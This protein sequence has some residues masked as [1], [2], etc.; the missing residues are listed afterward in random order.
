MSRW[1]NLN[2]LSLNVKKTKSMAFHMPRK[3]IIQPDIG[4]QINGSNIEFADN[5]VFLGITINNEL[6]WNSH[7][8]K[9]QTRYPRQ[10]VY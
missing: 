6:N 2:K 9:K 8:N 5:F 4:L 1:L 7:I 10:L 3:K